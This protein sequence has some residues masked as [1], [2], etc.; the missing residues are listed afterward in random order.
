MRPATLPELWIALAAVALA[1]A[2]LGGFALAG[3]PGEPNGCLQTFG[4]FCEAPRPGLV[5]QP[6]NTF[7]NVGFIAVGLGIAWEAGRRRAR[8]GAPSAGDPPIARGFLPGLCAV[9]VALLG[10]GS[11]ALHGSLTRW[12]GQADVLSMYLWAAL[13]LAYAALRAARLSSGAFAALF[14]GLCAVLAWTK[15][16]VAFSSDVI[17][18]LLV[19]GFAAGEAIVWRRRRDLAQDRRWLALSGALFGA[20]FAL[21]LPSRR[22]DGPLCD[23]HSLLQGHAAW[24][25][26][27]A[28]A[29]AAIWLYWRSERTE[30]TERD[31]RT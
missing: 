15:F 17:F 24:H 30:R 31:V 22:P 23:P 10:P 4:C 16:R 2:A 20:A 14:A 6:A 9:V 28:A 21:W 3:W 26:L 8:G 29:T 11:M 1:L 5:R 12:G 7:S 18:G 27:C 25:L 13:A 19:G